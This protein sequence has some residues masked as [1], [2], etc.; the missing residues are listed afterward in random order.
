M[1]LPSFGLTRDDIPDLEAAITATRTAGVDDVWTWGYE[2]CGH[3]THLATPDSPIVWEAVTAALT[4]AVRATERE[5]LDLSDLDL[6]PTADLIR[7][8]NAE[9]RRVADA[10]GAS[11]SAIKAVIDA[12]VER[13]E[14]GGRLIYVGA[15]S[16]G[17]AA[18]A[19]AAECGPTFA[20]D[21][22]VAV[23]TEVE[24]AEDDADAGAGDL[25]A[26]GAGPRDV[27]IGISA[28]GRTPYT[29]AAVEQAGTTAR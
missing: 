21:R 20:T 18:A 19:D 7:L 17:R 1:W 9:D 23:T 10:V 4:S 6:R 2:A 26:A 5:R 14:A 16:S 3:M 25:A 29:L 13:I 28:S 24:A 15:G 12:A 8:I 11:A 22:I 27:V